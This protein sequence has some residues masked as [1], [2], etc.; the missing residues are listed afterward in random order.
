M[1]IIVVVVIVIVGRAIASFGG[2][3]AALAVGGCD[4]LIGSI[5]GGWLR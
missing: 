4:G 3:I 1:V 5:I 2:V